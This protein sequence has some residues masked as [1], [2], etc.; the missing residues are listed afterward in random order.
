MNTGTNETKNKLLAAYST[1]L[2]LANSA[3][4]RVYISKMLLTQRALVLAQP[5]DH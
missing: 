3:A 5:Q 1:C 4:L 2:E